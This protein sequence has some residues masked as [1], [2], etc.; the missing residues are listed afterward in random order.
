MNAFASPERLR[1]A[2]HPLAMPPPGEP[3]NR[4]E[5]RGL[6]PDESVSMEAAVLVGIV[7]RDS[8][9]RIV[10]TRRTDGLRHHAGQ[11]S[12]PGGRMEAGDDGPLGTAR[13]EAWEEIGL[14][15]ASFEPLGYLDPMLTITGFRVTPVVGWIDPAFQP[16]PDPN[17]VAEVFEVPL[18]ELVAPGNMQAIDLHVAGRPRRVFEY[19][20]PGAGGRRIWGATALILHNLAQRL[21]HTRL[22]QA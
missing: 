2:L 17:E 6:L 8:I 1:R 15:P 18:A 5:L 14:V 13:R 22:E 7:V 21:E 12:F 20:G 3:Y 4:D 19:V 9:P 11:V 16:R 10:L